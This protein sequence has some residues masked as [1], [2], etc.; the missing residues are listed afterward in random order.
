MNLVNYGLS[1]G[2]M[3]IIKSI[4]IEDVSQTELS[5]IDEQILIKIKETLPQNSQDSTPAILFDDYRCANGKVISGLLF[6]EGSNRCAK[7]DGHIS[8]RILKMLSIWLVSKFDILEE[9]RNDF[10]LIKFK[11]NEYILEIDSYEVI[12]GAQEKIL[13]KI[14]ISDINSPPVFINRD[15]KSNGFYSV[16]GLGFSGVSHH[17]MII[18]IGRC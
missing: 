3:N 14:E 17:D 16:A 11:S 8:S 12:T 7:Y 10:R 1:Y 4:S 9:Q 2:E 6:E 15:H 5:L 18:N 13:E